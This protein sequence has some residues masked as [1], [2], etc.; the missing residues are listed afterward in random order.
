MHVVI[1]GLG[2]AGF[3]AARAIRET[4]PETTVSIYTDEDHLY[5]PRPRLYEVLSG[6]VNPRDI[7]TFPQQWYENRGIEVCMSEKA[8]SINIANKEILLEND[9]AINYDELLLANGARPFIP[10]V[11]GVEKTGVFTLRTIK[12]AL[13]IKEYAKKTKKATVVGGG[14]LGL[15]F[16]ASLRKLGQEVE[17]VELFPRLLPMQLDQDGAA[18]LKNRIEA[19][20]ITITLGVKTTEVLG[21]EAFS[22]IALDNGKELSADFALFCAG[23]RSNLN[24]AANAEIKVNKG[25]IVD[26]YLQTSANDVYAAGDVA[27]S[28]G[29]VY[30]IIPAAEEQARIAAMN[31]LEKDKRIYKGTIPSNTLKIVGMNLTSMGIVNPETS[32]YEEI[33][34]INQEEGIYKKI[35]LDQ[36]KIVGAIILG[37]MRMAAAVRRLMDLG[38]DISKYKSF[39]LEEDFDYRKILS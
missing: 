29:K 38:T 2:V 8:R 27:E 21:R 22:G 17:V 9:R 30:G 18:I 26:Q 11:K 1:V 7:Y 39:L 24:L 15:E 16:A 4:N 32:K 3:T 36:G 19:L 23:I 28:E 10:P 31:M 12:D 25:V 14:L 6:E 20:G 33:K 13:T 35:V 5:Y 37:D 34:R